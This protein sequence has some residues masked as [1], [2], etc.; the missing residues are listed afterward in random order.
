M[1]S[2]VRHV[3]ITIT[4]ASRDGPAY[5]TTAYHWKH[6]TGL[7]LA[8]HDP[9]SSDPIDIIIG[10]DLVCSFSTI[11]KRFRTSAY[12]ESTTLGWILSEPI[13]SFPTTE[14]ISVLA[15]SSRS[16]SSLLLRN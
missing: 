13:A 15:L 10:A 7:E 14:S 6:V 5:I 12:Y 3:Q 2:V 16:R 8:D 4:L 11:S 9:M 1:Q